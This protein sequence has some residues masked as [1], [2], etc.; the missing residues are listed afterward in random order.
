MKKSELK[1]LIVEALKKPAE[2]ARYVNDLGAEDALQNGIVK[3]DRELIEM[4]LAEIDRLKL[5]LVSCRKAS[6]R[7]ISVIDSNQNDADRISRHVEH[8]TKHILNVVEE[9]LRGTRWWTN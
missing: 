3:D 6:K 4:L 7:L 8:E 5:N 1:E 2:V 9:S